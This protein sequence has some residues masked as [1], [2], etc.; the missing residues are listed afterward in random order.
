MTKVMTV[1]AALGVGLA[2]TSL[3]AAGASGTVTESNPSSPDSLG[4]AAEDLP[5]VPA[6]AIGD[7]LTTAELEDLATVAD[8]RGMTFEQAVIER[9]PGRDFSLLAGQLEAQFPN[10][11]AGARFDPVGGHEIAWSDEAPSG[12][13]QLIAL[14]ETSEATRGSSIH[15]VGI[16]EQRGFTQRELHEKVTEVHM[17]LWADPLVREASTAADPT[18]GRIN[19]VVR[20]ADDQSSDSEVVDLLE[21][22]HDLGADVDVRVRRTAIGT[23]HG[24]QY[25]GE[26]MSTCTSGFTVDH[27][28]NFDGIATAGHCGNNQSMDGDNFPTT[29]NEYEGTYGD[30]Q[31]HTN[32]YNSTFPDDF[33]SGAAS[34][35]ETNLRDV[36]S[37]GTPTV[38]Q[39]VCRNGK[40]THKHCDEI[41][42]LGHCVNGSCNLVRVYNDTADGGDS[43]GPVFWGNTA[44]G[45]HKGNN[46]HDWARRDVFTRADYIPTGVG[47][48]VRS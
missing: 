23:D 11:F 7:P 28:T 14:F 22:R 33:Y 43:G 35:L 26:V 1:G 30:M 2:L 39:D 9:G 42:A 44:Y 24:T 17:A 5:D 18:T 41:K 27:P 4:L 13:A 21:Q 40:T 48:T 16:V 31:I 46:W 12:A 32:G 15:A 29:Y 20:P 38:G 19:A 3:G 47:Y 45:L 10:D 36:S 8:E 37:V 6:P 34:V 25:G